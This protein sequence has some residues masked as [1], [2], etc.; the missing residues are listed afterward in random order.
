MT[1]ECFSAYH[2]NALKDTQIKLKT[3]KNEKKVARTTQIIRNRTSFP[4]SLFPL[5]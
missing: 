2:N 5:G 4:G 3:L 1:L